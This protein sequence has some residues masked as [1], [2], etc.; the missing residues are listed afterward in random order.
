MSVT[1]HREKKHQ[2][3]L[4]AQCGKKNQD[5]F[6]FLFHQNHSV[7]PERSLDKGMNINVN[8]VFS[9]TVAVVIDLGFNWSCK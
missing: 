2:I 5:S 8:A 4:V 3:N 6:Q 7:K 9:C 1:F